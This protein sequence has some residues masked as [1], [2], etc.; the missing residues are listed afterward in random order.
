MLYPE[1]NNSQTY[2]SNRKCCSIELKIASYITGC[3]GQHASRFKE[4]SQLQKPWWKHADK[5]SLEWRKCHTSATGWLSS[6]FL[7]LRIGGTLPCFHPPP[8]RGQ[9]VPARDLFQG[10]SASSLS[11]VGDRQTLGRDQGCAPVGVIGQLPGRRGNRGPGR[12]KDIPRLRGS[13]YPTNIF[14]WAWVGGAE[15]NK[16][17]WDPGRG[18]RVKGG[19]TWAGEG[20]RAGT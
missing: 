15:T 4:D 12:V 17:G 18:L 14:N 16:K 10:G 11:G 5:K 7:P 2:P 3:P 9:L 20:D 6:F 19:G 1:A 13:Q 8:H